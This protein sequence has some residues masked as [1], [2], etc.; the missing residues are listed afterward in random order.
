MIDSIVG[1]DDDWTSEEEID[2]PEFRDLVEREQI[3]D[4]YDKV[5]GR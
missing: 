2:D 4:K 1:D 3:V 5:R